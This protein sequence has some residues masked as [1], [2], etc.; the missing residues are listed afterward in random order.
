MLQCIFKSSNHRDKHC[1][2]Q[3]LKNNNNKKKKTNNCSQ[4]HSQQ[5]LHQASGQFLF[6][7]C[8]PAVLFTTKTAHTVPA[9]CQARAHSIPA[10]CQATAHSIPAWCQA[11][12]HSIPAWC[13]AKAHSML[14]LM[15]GSSTQYAVLNTRQ[16]HTVCRAQYQAT[17]HNMPCSIP[18][19]STQYAVLNTRQ[20]HT[21]CR[22]Q[23]QA[24]AHNMPC[25]IPGN[26]TQYAVLA[27][28]QR[29][30]S[31]PARCHPTAHSMLHWPTQKEHTAYL[32]DARLEHAVQWPPLHVLL[33]DG[34]AVEDMQGKTLIRWTHL[35]C[36]GLVFFWNP[37]QGK[38]VSSAR[39]P[40]QLVS[41]WTQTWM[42]PLCFT[43]LFQWC[44]LGTLFRGSTLP[45][46]WFM[47][48]V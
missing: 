31:V 30:H 27:N 26:S 37:S 42:K 2:D 38:R 6:I 24:A 8:L 12:A 29:A 45:P 46:K 41:K 47:G 7:G 39:P 15:P 32:L 5:P 13:Q 19:S 21:I 33:D 43:F 44:H 35:L 11:T 48:S 20:Q 9:R 1:C 3:K 22:A 25:S 16:Q 23:Y 18:G 34:E 28:T 40:A 36:G 17:A 4:I 14:Y 10:W